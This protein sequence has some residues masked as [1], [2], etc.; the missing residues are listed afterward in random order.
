[1]LVDYVASIG[2]CVTRG[3]RSRFRLGLSLDLLTPGAP[4]HRRPPLSRL[5]PELQPSIRSVNIDAMP[6]LRQPYE[7]ELCCTPRDPC[8][9]F[10]R[11]RLRPGRRPCPPVL[12]PA[13]L[14]CTVREAGATAEVS[15]RVVRPVQAANGTA[16]T[17]LVVREE[18]R[19]VVEQRDRHSIVQSCL[20]LLTTE[21]VYLRCG[22]SGALWTGR[23]ESTSDGAL[24]ASWQARHA[25]GQQWLAEPGFAPAAI[26]K[27]L[28][29]LRNHHRAHTQVS[30][31]M[32]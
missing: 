23:P 8:E 3:F 9:W 11:P 13:A 7:P 24:F 12:P 15:L 10:S 30:G 2:A 16:D 31:P 17:T 29:G 28:N 19:P 22:V 14:Y 5:P 20:Q 21:A 6:A 18:L 1:M 32:A 4:H 27:S 25:M 26:R